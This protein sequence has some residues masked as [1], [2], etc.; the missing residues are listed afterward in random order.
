[1]VISKGRALPETSAAV[2]PDL[3]ALIKRSVDRTE[4]GE[5]ADRDRTPV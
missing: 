5:E 3:L 2:V 4:S 1:M